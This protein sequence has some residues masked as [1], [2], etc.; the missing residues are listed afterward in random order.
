MRRETPESA[1]I[2]LDGR[3]C[4]DFC[5]NDYL[6]LAAHPQVVEAFIDAARMH[7]VGARASHLVTGHQALH[8]ALERELAAFTGRERAI[9]FSTGYM[10]N[11]GLARA[12]ARR[13]DAVYG[14]ELN[15]ASLIDGGRLSGAKLHRYPHVDVAAL[16]Q[17]LAAQESG[18]AL[19]LTDGVF[20]MD[21]ELAP[22]PALAAACSRHAA[23]LAVDD[24]H[25]LGVIGETGR[26]SLEQFGLTPTQVPALVGTFGKAFGTFGAFVAGSEDLIETLIQRARTYIYTTA[27]PPAVAAATRAALA[28][29]IAEP[30]RRER[31]L[32][33]TRR[34][35][36]LAT[37]AGI[38]LGP[39]E[40]PI[41][42]ILLGSAE[43]AMRASNALLER[44]FFVAAIRPPTVPAD[45]SRL[46]IT[47]ST[48]HRDAEVEGLV[49]AL[50]DVVS[51]E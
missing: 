20:S 32:A 49:A 31:V 22:L 28:V 14:D 36:E 34:F 50:A 3:R 46:R 6:G 18:T 38:K 42:P 37:A 9:V 29:S 51:P 40:T 7:G 1:E 15:H 8:E 21:G 13:E 41:Q 23:Y 35:R 43:A 2:E 39:S 45:T 27:L 47:L 30:W 33:L 19:V 17:Q 48:A 24:A 5:S 16:E 26:G 11:L 4:V 12:L 25:G 10:A 44:G